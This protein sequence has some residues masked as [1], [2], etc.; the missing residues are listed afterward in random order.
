MTGCIHGG[1]AINSLSFIQVYSS[2][3]RYLLAFY[4]LISVQPW[5]E[6]HIIGVRKNQRVENPQN[7]YEILEQFSHSHN[8]E[9]IYGPQ[10]SSRVLDCTQKVSFRDTIKL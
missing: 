8:R 6:I 9:I 3:C 7:E 1:S 4:L 5:Q 2:Y 10:A